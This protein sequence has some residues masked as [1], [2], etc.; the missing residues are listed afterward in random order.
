MLDKIT[1]IAK[2]AGN[3]IRKGFKQNYTIKYKSSEIDLVTSID[4]AS[5]KCVIDFIKKEFP[6]HGILS[7]ESGNVK[8]G[9]DYLWVID[10][11]D[12][13]TNFAHGLPIFS[14]SIAL[15]YKGVTTW[16]V[17]YDVMRDSLYS[18]ELNNG[19]YENEEIIKVSTGN[20]LPTAFL[21]T[22]FP[23]DLKEDPNNAIEKFN[24]FLVNSRAIRRLGSAA[25]DL[26]YVASGVF[27]G[28]WEINLKP[29][30]IAAGK[31]LVEEAGGLTSDFN[32]NPINIYDKQILAT[33]K[34]IHNDMLKVLNS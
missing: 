8:T 20:N 16:G 3:I 21:V 18:A 4:E 15:Q 9:G 29:W 25:I 19:A 10:P 30:D 14:V 34:L 27:D 13:T 7:E 5:E 32:N 22:G 33:N 6:T 17:V 1:Y 28:F 12:G 11:L 24:N 2:E 26:C 31:L 23:Y